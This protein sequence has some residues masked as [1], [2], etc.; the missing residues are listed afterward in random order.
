MKTGINE[1]KIFKYDGRKHNSKQ[2]WN[3]DKC[4]CFFKTII[5]Y[6]SRKENH[7][8]NT[9]ICVC[10]YNE[11]CE[12]DEY[13]KNHTCI[14]SIIHNKTIYKMDY[15]ISHTFLVVTIFLLLLIIIVI[16]PYYIQHKLKQNYITTLIYKMIGSN[17][18]KQIHIKNCTFYHFE[19]IININDFNPKNIKVDKF[20]KI[21]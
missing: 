21:L 20:T 14:K 1:S 8:W 17:E 16:N 15:Y 2:K 5:K 10:V 18:L 6:H 19:D 3:K 11:T 12:T 7:I 13:L 4:Q 9:R